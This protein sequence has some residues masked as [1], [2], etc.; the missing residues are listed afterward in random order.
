MLNIHAFQ[1]IENKC[2]QIA[3]KQKISFA[4][5]FG[6]LSDEQQALYDEYMSCQYKRKLNTLFGT[7]WTKKATP[8]MLYKVSVKNYKKHICSL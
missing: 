1:A 8:L 4:Q 5:A 7:E 3:N 6:L 2:N